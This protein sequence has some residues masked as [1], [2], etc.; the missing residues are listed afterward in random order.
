MTDDTNASPWVAHTAQLLQA[1]NIICLL[2]TS[3]CV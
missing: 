1:L 3:R 2:Y